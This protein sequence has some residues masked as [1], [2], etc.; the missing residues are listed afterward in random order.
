[1]NMLRHNGT[2][3]GIWISRGS[4]N[5][6]GFLWGGSQRIYDYF[7]LR[8][9]NDALAQENFELRMRLE[10]LESLIPEETR[11]IGLSGN[12]SRNYRFIPAEISKISN[13]SQH[14]YMIIGKGYED[15]VTEGSGVITGKGAVGIIDAVSRKHAYARS[16]KNHEMNISARLGRGGAVGPLSWNGRSSSGAILKEI[17]HHVEFHPGDTVYTS[18]Y[19][20]I[21][22]AD[23]PLGT[24]GK[25]RIVNGATYEIDV[26][27]F[28][29]FASLRHVTI[30]ENL[31][32][33][34]MK[35][36]E[37]EK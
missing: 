26:T 21:F 14:N 33:D 3:Q 19:S 23:I 7:S 18:G 31:G 15:G 36:L 20:S 24:A 1:M 2:I 32:R 12:I 25:A 11:N 29:D 8:E 34:E 10:Q 16:F 4:Q 37:G 9:K 27:L 35:R 5:V 6:M 30:V 28:E 13:N 22:P 17:P